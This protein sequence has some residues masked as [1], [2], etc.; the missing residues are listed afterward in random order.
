MASIPRPDLDSQRRPSTPTS[1][2]LNGGSPLLD[3]YV[4]KR[5]S[6]RDHGITELCS[7]GEAPFLDI[8]FIHGLQGHA[9]K[10]WTYID[11]GSRQPRESRRW[12]SRLGE[13]HHSRSCSPHSLDQTSC[14]WPADLLPQDVPGA[15]ILTYGYDANVS[16]F[17]EEC[18]NQ[19]SITAHSE[20]LLNA[21]AR[22]RPKCPQRP[23][24]FVVH[25]LGGVILKSVRGSVL[26]LG[27]DVANL[28]LGAET[29]FRRRRRRFTLDLRI[30]IC[31]SVFWDTSSWQLVC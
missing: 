24:L 21:L 15:R 26:I 16:H 1:P 4:S 22:W 29:V 19:N 3:N 25:S 10:T 23:L 18:V 11:Q 31:N 8:V 13:G 20:S 5:A 30:H 14:F 12:L 2:E 6:V 7:G 9:E 28:P 27:P 17:F